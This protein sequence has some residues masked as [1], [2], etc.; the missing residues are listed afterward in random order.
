MYYRW[1][2]NSCDQ[3]VEVERPIS[4]AEVPPAEPCPSCQSD[5]FRKIIALTAPLINH[6]RA[7]SA[8]PFRF[9][10][11]EGEVVTFTGKRQQ[12]DWMKRN[13]YRLHLDTVG[14]DAMV[15]KDC[16]L[17]NRDP[18]PPSPRAAEM[19][20]KATWL[21]SDELQQALVPTLR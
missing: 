6:F 5:G 2:C 8:Y 15:G 4:K 13:G 3:E 19:A 21:T 11:E 12:D 18:I 7:Q 20:Q 17:R 1:R 9:K 14:R 10:S 16:Q